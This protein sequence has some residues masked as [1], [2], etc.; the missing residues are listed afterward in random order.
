MTAITAITVQNT[1]GVSAVH[2]VPG[3]IIVRQVRAVLSD[4]G[5]DAV[6]VGMLANAQIVLA[7][8]QALEELEPGETRARPRRRER[9]APQRSGGKEA[10]C[11]R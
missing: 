1:V 4:I 11:Q 3:E 8:T 9:S 2:E 7:V 10:S 5:V 6:K